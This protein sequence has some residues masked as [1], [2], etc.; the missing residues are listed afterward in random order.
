MSTEALRLSWFGRPVLPPEFER[1]LNQ[2]MERHVNVA[3]AKERTQLVGTPMT[4]S[5]PSPAAPSPS[6]GDL[7]VMSRISAGDER[8]LGTLYDRYS[9]FA[10]SLAVAIVREGS[11]A[12]EVVAETFS[13]VWRTAAGF[14]AK[15]GSVAAWLSTIVRTRSLDLIRSQKRRAK[16]LDQAAA[17]T[18][19]GAS[20]G[21]STGA[22]EADRGAEI[23]EAQVLVRRSLN[24]LPMAQRQVLELAY[25][26]GLSQSEIAAQLNEPLGT[27]KTR[28]RAG[29]EKMRQS[30]GPIMGGAR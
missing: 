25:F 28:M 6:P 26:G 27:I 20:P 21:L 9:T 11:D 13:Q 3:S 24:E 7:E 14:D 19:E 5:R 4:P 17:M 2:R 30:L 10:Y 12:E 18:E 29:M 1:P 23:S 8:A 16:M 15:R 22:P